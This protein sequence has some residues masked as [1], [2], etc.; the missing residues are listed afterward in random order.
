MGKDK[1]WAYWTCPGSSNT[2]QWELKI[3]WEIKI[4]PEKF[5]FNPTISDHSQ[6]KQLCIRLVSPVKWENS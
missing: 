2:D 3:I 6:N 5:R 1:I 4:D